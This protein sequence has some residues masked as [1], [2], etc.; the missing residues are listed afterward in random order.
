[1]FK[2][3]RGKRIILIYS[4][5]IIFFGMLSVFLFLDI[6]SLNSTYAF[7]TANINI[8]GMCTQNKSVMVFYY[9][10]DC[11]SCATEYQAFQNVTSRFGTGSVE[12]Y[13]FQSP[14]FCAWDLNVSAYNKGQT[15][16]APAAAIEVFS[17]FSQ[18]KVPFVLFGGVGVQ[19]YKI[20]GFSTESTAVQD[21]LHY[22]CLAINNIAPACTST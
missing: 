22:V 16:N 6:N 17:T 12:N 18:S 4:A 21:L 1:M 11:S 13:T 15:I 5:I 8:S 7:Q 20:G 2:V 10:N 3:K 19:Y 14:Y 9:A